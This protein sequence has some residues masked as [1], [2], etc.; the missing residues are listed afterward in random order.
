MTSNIIYNKKNDNIFTVYDDISGITFKDNILSPNIA[1]PTYKGNT[2]KEGFSK[3]DLTFKEKNGLKLP[4]GIKNIG[5]DTT[6]PRPTRENTGVSWYPK[7][8][9]TIKFGFGKEIAVSPGENK[10]FEAV[11]NSQ[12]G[13]VLILESG[14]T[15]HQSK[16]ID[17]NHSLTIK[18]ASGGNKPMITFERSSLFNIE[19]GGSLQL[20]GLNFNGSECDDYAG[21][22]VVRTSKY[23]MV[24]NYKF[25][26]KDCDFVDL[27][28]NHSFNVL[29]AYKNTFADS[30]GL[31]GCNFSDVSGT[32]LS[33]NA[34]IEDRG[35]YN[36]ENVVIDK[37]SF[38]NI[39]GAALTLHRGGKDESTFGPILNLT[40]TALKM[41]DMIKEI[42]VNLL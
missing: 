10:L 41:L 36:A 18:S 1:F 42:K 22:T 17:L 3:K 23:S 5:P 38:K 30:I 37:C 34:E 29:K 31:V 15:Y 33:L 2:Q 16:S 27:D 9:Y 25:F 21:N 4:Q 40:E 28:V 11:K 13:D 39:G 8:D 35:I 7:K 19:N 32:V 6:I 20:E 14:A 12:S 26:A 24:D